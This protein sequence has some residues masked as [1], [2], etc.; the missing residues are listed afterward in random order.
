MKTK[1]SQLV[2]IK[3]QKVDSIENIIAVLN[4]YKEELKEDIKKVAE[5]IKNIKKPKSGNFSNFISQNYSFSV[6]M[7]IKRK[8]EQMLSQK[9][10]EIDI[11][12]NEYKKALVDYEKIKY[13]EDLTIQE[14]IKKL[15]KDEEKMLDEISVL[16]YKRRNA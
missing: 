16:T 4:R 5:D 12:T 13:L 15:K 3:K 14:R 9:M 8:K 10:K 2:K 1:Y 7:K 6:L 11:A